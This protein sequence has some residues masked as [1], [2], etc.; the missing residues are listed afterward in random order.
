MANSTSQY[1]GSS[2]RFREAMAATCK[3]TA[4]RQGQA[5]AKALNSSNESAAIRRANADGKLAEGTVI[6]RRRDD[7]R[8]STAAR[9]GER[10]RATEAEWR[11]QGARRQGIAEPINGGGGARPPNNGMQRRP[12]S[13]VL[14]VTGEAVRGPADAWVL[15]ALPAIADERISA[16]RWVGLGRSG[17]RFICCT[18]PLTDSK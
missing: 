8:R 16:R 4:H 12:R 17:S 13:Q 10:P 3:T 18:T 2:R 6:R 9:P 11:G 14:I 1:P 15:G 7:A 5:V